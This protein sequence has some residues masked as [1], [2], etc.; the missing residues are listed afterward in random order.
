MDEWSILSFNSK[1][2]Y[3][4]HTFIVYSITVHAS[5]IMWEVQPITT[6]HLADMM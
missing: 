1:V 6:R 2:K 5:A 4:F 3:R